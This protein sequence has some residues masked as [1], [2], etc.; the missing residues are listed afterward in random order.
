M[1]LIVG[2]E[3]CWFVLVCVGFVGL[4][5]AFECKLVSVGLCGTL[6]RADSGI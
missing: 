5:V 3:V 2:F 1:G 4:F 6:V